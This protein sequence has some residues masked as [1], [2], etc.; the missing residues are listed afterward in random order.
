M[1]ASAPHLPFKAPVLGI[2]ISLASYDEVL[3]LIDARPQNQATTVAFCNVHS[4][5]TARRDP[6]IASAL[7]H[8][9]V[10]TPDGMPLVW[11]LR[12]TAH[13][14]QSRVAGPELMTRALRY[15]VNRR[16]KHFFYGSTQETLEKLRSSAE[17]LAPGVGIVGTYSPPFRTPT[18]REI[19][20]AVRR[21]REAGADV[22]WVGLS[23]PKQ[24]VWIDQVRDRLPGVALL[25]VG[26]AFDV[27]AGNVRRAPQWMQDLSLEWLYRLFQEP[28]RLWRRYV[29]NNPAYLILLIDQIIRQRLSR[30]DASH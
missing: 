10:A 13:T 8:F 24:E 5:M 14:A 9:D 17:S 6:R 15:G 28:K 21:I 25:G 7:D 18:D 16:W 22:V 29:F 19:G 27:L 26:A 20:D 1:R 30:R 4:V 3:E 11:A 2:P 12:A 23:M